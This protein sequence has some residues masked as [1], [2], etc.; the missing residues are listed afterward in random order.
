MKLK[1]SNNINNNQL[2][3]SRELIHKNN[4]KIYKILLFIIIQNY[5][6]KNNKIN[7]IQKFLIFIKPLSIQL[8][9]ELN[10]SRIN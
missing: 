10:Y 1:P 5:R 9:G 4:Y 8:K 3:I 2:K 7:V 6:I